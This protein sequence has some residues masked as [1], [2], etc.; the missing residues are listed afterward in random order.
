[1]AMT[2]AAFRQPNGRGSSAVVVV[3]GTGDKLAWTRSDAL[4]APLE[5]AAVALAARGEI[6]SGDAGKLQLSTRTGTSDRVRQFGYRWLARLDDLKPGRYQIRAV[7]G[8]G[9]SNQGSVWYDLEIPDFS[10]APLTMS[11]VLLESEVAV[12]RLTIRPDKLLAA[13]LPGPPTTLREFFPIDTVA[14]YVEVYDNQTDKAHDVETVV[15][16]TNE[17]GEA[18][19]QSREK[20]TTQEAAGSGGVYGVRTKMSMEKLPPG[21]YVLAVEAR[22]TQNRAISTGRAVPFQ[23]VAAGAVSGGNK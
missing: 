1:M 12:Q 17:N 10:K 3:E 23:V 20:R 5:L 7:A 18:V 11:D 19:F 6:R 16:V 15:T 2:A 14:M 13:A 8:N 22:Q 4:A 9:P 21:R